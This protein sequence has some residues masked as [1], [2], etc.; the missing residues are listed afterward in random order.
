MNA[1]ASYV[2]VI[3]MMSTALGVNNAFIYLSS[4]DNFT[5]TVYRSKFA[6][7][8]TF[9]LTGVPE[10]TYTGPRMWSFEVINLREEVPRHSKYLVTLFKSILH[11]KML[12][13]SKK[14]K[15]KKLRRS[16]SYSEVRNVS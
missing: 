10:I 6:R 1:L 13:D 15:R 8:A 16:W 9:L 11:G 12:S 3:R 14:Q 4:I 5:C 7:M 2:S